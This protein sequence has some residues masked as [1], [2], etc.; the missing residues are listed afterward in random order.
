M[1][2]MNGIEWPYDIPGILSTKDDK[3][4]ILLASDHANVITQP[5]GRHRPRC[6][7]IGS[8]DRLMTS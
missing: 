8:A 5:R 3:M 6:D 4:T 7:G 1:N 2:E